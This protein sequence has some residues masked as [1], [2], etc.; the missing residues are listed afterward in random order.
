MTTASLL[1]GAFSCDIEFRRIRVPQFVREEK[2]GVTYLVARDYEIAYDTT[3][4]FANG[5]RLPIKARAFGELNRRVVI[6]DAGGRPAKISGYVHGRVEISNESGVVIFRGSYYDSRTIQ[7]LAGDD[8]L[9]AVGEAVID[10]WESGFG[11]G[12]YAGHAFG[13]G[14][15]LTRDDET[16]LHGE[17]RGQ[18]D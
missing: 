6:R 16:P 1:T 7:A 3:L 9:T 5:A 18:I 8:A 4:R 15:R 11:E 12:P 2:D 14:G 13:L 10:H 17:A